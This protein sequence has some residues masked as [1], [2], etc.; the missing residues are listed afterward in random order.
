M[1]VLKYVRYSTHTHTHSQHSTA[2]NQA[3]V[4]DN[5]INNKEMCV[6]VVSCAKAKQLPQQKKGPT[7]SLHFEM[8]LNP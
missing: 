1:R 3:K 8:F 7:E 2:Q 4:K 5:K 6:V